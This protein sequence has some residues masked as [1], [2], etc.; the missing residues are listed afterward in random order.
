MNKTL[1]FLLLLF[2]CLLFPLLASSSADARLQK[3]C[4]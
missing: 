4:L 1:V 3:R 2:P